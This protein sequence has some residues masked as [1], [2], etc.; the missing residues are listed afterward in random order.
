[1]NAVQ[2]P[3]AQPWMERLGWALLHFI[4]QGGLIAGGFAL[5]RGRLRGPQARYVLGCAALA[6]MMAA[7]LA[8]FISM[9]RTILVTSPS[10]TGA[11]PNASGV[12]AA[13]GTW[14]ADVWTRG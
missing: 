3:L 14:D 2:F 10:R 13:F 4:W 7:P 1:M 6:A 12:G 11:L 8:T 9:G 5:L